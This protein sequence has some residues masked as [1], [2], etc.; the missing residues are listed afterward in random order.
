MTSLTERSSLRKRIVLYEDYLQLKNAYINLKEKNDKLK[1]EKQKLESLLKKYQSNISDYKTSNNTINLLFKKFEKKIKELNDFEKKHYKEF[2]MVKNNNFRIIDTKKKAKQK[3]FEKLYISHFKDEVIFIKKINDKKKSNEIN[4]EEYNKKIN[5]YIEIINQLK[6]EIKL[7]E[8]LY[9]NKN[10]IDENSLIKNTNINIKERVFDNLSISKSIQYNLVCILKKMNKK[11]YIASKACEYKIMDNKEK[12]KKFKNKF[13]I[14]NIEIVSKNCELCLIKKQINKHI[15]KNDLII[16]SKICEINLINHPLII[17]KEEKKDKIYLQISSTKLSLLSNVKKKNK[18]NF[19][20]S[21]KTS[22][23][24]I[25]QKEKMKC[26]LII[27]SKICEYN[28][29]NKNKDKLKSIEIKKDINEKKFFNSKLYKSSKTNELT[30]LSKNKLKNK[31]FINL[32]ISTNHNELSIYQNISKTNNLNKLS[33]NSNICNINILKPKKI[34]ISY[35]SKKVSELYIMGYSKTEIKNK[36][37]FDNIKKKELFSKCKICE[38]NFEGLN[39]SDSL[40]KINGELKIESNINVFQIIINKN[41]KLQ[42]KN[43][44]I[45]VETINIPKTKKISFNNLNISFKSSEIIFSKSKI[46]SQILDIE[47][48]QLNYLGIKKRKK[49]KNVETFLGKETQKAIID[50][51]INSINIGFDKT[52]KYLDYDNINKEKNDEDSDDE[53]DKLEC[54]PIPSFILCIQKKEK[55]K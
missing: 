8:E 34:P 27:S 36:N 48:C 10:K 2:S 53:N 47:K 4:V 17:S 42:I 46:K 52:K 24:H 35:F 18:N 54:E 7:K 29:L 23:F 13:N 49:E 14:N 25:Y 55:L 28:I 19:I 5:K 44:V 30:I 50:N 1:E 6:K 33:I 15:T 26:E 16:S 43:E 40:K 31:L 37:K 39:K 38:I 21:S 20:I 9:K 12:D 11:N 45:N 3:S 22:E 32:R 41:K 51:Y